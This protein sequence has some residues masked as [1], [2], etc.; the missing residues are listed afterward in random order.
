M[1]EVLDSPR[2]LQCWLSYFF[3]A[4]TGQVPKGVCLTT[5]VP[6]AGVERTSVELCASMADSG[7]SVVVDGSVE[8]LRA[9]GSRSKANE[10]VRFFLKCC[11]EAED[12]GVQGTT[13]AML[14]LG[15]AS[16]ADNWFAGSGKQLAVQTE[17]VAALMPHLPSKKRFQR[18]VSGTKL[19]CSIGAIRPKRARTITSFVKAHRGGSA[20]AGFAA[21]SCRN[22]MVQ[23]VA[24]SVAWSRR[25]FPGSDARRICIS[26][27]EFN[28]ESSRM[29]LI[30]RDVRSDVLGYLPLQVM[31]HRVEKRAMVFS[32][33]FFHH[34]TLFLDQNAKMTFFCS[35]KVLFFDRKKGCQIMTF[36][37][38]F[39]T[40]FLNM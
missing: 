3:V 28:K 29:I 19:L 13:V 33:S 30:F 5:M 11:H 25:V 34:C 36:L 1:E 21:Q 7:T 10:L 20:F 38:F 26:A 24:S 23:V 17:D 37:S 14:V 9:L 22:V 16:V 35:K 8:V 4:S 40:L 31:P 27:D 32:C 18:A 6:T 39:D 15:L 12:E 2:R